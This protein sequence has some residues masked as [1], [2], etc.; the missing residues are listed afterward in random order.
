MLKLKQQRLKQLYFENKNQILENQQ[1]QS[2]EKDILPL[3]HDKQ[4]FANDKQSIADDNQLIDYANQSITDDKQSIADDEQYSEGNDVHVEDVFKKPRISLKKFAY[5][6]L[7]QQ[8]NITNPERRIA[9]FASSLCFQM[10]CSRWATTT[11]ITSASTRG[12]LLTVPQ[13]RRM[14]RRSSG[15]GSSLGR[16]RPSSRWRWRRSLLGSSS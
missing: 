16:T 3:V 9:K 15:G 1:L 2:D 6:T 11:S 12:A 5:G 7:P 13:R 14:R 8:E 4:S 10:I